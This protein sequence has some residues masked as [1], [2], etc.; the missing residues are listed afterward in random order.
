MTD[1]WYRDAIFYSLHVRSFADSNG[2]GIG[3]FT[4]LT[5]KLDYLADLGVTALWVLPFFPSPGRD[6]G[7]DIADYHTVNPDYGDLR[8]FRRFLNAAHDRGLKVVTE[9][10]VNHTSDQH[11]W[12]QRARHAP[13]GSSWRDFYVW[14]DTTDRYADAR[15]IFQDFE[16]SNWTWDPEAGAYFWHRFYSHQPDLNY[17][18]PDVEEAVFDVLG[19]WLDMGVDGVRLDAVP[20][21]YEREGTNCENLPET[22]DVLKRLRKRIDDEYEGRMMLAEANQWPEDSAAYFGD[23]DECHMNFH[24]P[25]MPRLFMAVR[26]EHRMPIVDILEQTPAPPPGCQWATF[27]R[28]HDEL[29][30][31]MVTDEERDLMLRA[32]AQDAQMRINLGIRRRLAPLL[33]NDRRKI[34][35]LNALLFS[36]PGTPV[37]YYGD[38][39]GMGDNVYLGDR[40]GVR[41]PMQWTADRNAGFSSAN[42]H[43]LYLPLITEQGYHY[44]TVNV[45]AQQANPS[46]L[47][48]WMR[49]LISLRKRHRVF[50]RG[51]I[52]F[53]EPDN[54]HVLAFV[55]SL[56]SDAPV[57]CVA[58][59]SRLAQHVEL[60]LR[61]WINRTPVELFGQNR[62][63][64]IGEWPYYLTLQPYGF[65]WFALTG[66]ESIADA[67]GLPSLSG[68]FATVLRR[69]SSLA[70]VLAKW[71]PK[72]RW[73]AAKG[74]T[75]R[76]VVHRRRVPHRR[77]SRSARGV[78]R[79]AGDVH[80][81]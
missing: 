54:P 42:P 17:D 67:D 2:D 49:Q 72:Q 23:G 27:L 32:Y 78:G 48:S 21:L 8:S 64:S 30:L 57:L 22:H 18:N 25:V 12:F 40:N 68:D 35:L 16:T 34:E 69:R 47:F 5:R 80:R 77:A 52:T 10:V 6:D 75:M 56:D 71:I 73:F 4:G 28:N 7:Y 55:R 3:D 44:E 31:E 79:R 70:R 59:L 9:L 76:D 66:A 33:G 39:I 81:G 63:A 13:A 45:E 60:D 38:E 37:I 53:L 26:T 51:E 61:P 29:T 11:P 36:L 62:F 65:F 58:N 41:T 20:Y 15:I 19:F 24:F 50:G 1:D 43:R 74:A 14:S 46:S